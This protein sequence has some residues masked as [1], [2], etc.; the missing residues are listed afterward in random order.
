MPTN[1]NQLNE[2]ITSEKAAQSGQNIDLQ[3]SLD[4]ASEVVTLD[5]KEIR[6]GSFSNGETEIVLQRHGK[7][8]RDK[9]DPNAGQLTTEAVQLETESAFRYFSELIA[10]VPESERQGINVLFVSSDTSYANNGQRS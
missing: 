6:P 1:Y 8:I 7:Y 5:R 10:Q 2:R 3:G 4:Q 9:D